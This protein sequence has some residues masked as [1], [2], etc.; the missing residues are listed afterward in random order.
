[1]SRARSEAANSRLDPN[2]SINNA[3]RVSRGK[4]LM[5]IMGIP[6]GRGDRSMV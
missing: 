1:M 4:C 5:P 3:G 6:T 2:A